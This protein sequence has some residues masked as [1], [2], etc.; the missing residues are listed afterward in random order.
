M[1]FGGGTQCTRLLVDTLFTES[2]YWLCNSLFLSSYSCAYSYIPNKV[3]EIECEDA[4]AGDVTQLVE[5]PR[6]AH[7]CWACSERDVNWV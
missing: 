5:F 6:W 4:E 7:E 1:G 2:S 3:C